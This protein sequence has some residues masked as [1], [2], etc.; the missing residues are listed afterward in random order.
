MEDIRANYIVSGTSDGG[1]CHELG[2]LTA[3]S[4][5]SRSSSFQSSDTLLKDF[6]KK[7]AGIKKLPS[8][9]THQKRTTVGLPMLS[10]IKVSAEYEQAICE[11]TNRE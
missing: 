1:D 7:K 4:R 9:E 10:W 6:L 2:S 8:I 5:D 3:G 11:P